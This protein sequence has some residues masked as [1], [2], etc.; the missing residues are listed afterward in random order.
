MLAGVEEAV[1]MPRQ[2]RV[3]VHSG[4]LTGRYEVWFQPRFPG[5]FPAQHRFGGQENDIQ[6]PAAGSRPDRLHD[7]RNLGQVR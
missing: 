5:T 1:Q 7:H 4:Q 3:K 6:R 2:R